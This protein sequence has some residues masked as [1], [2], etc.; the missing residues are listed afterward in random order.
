MRQCDEKLNL[1]QQ[2]KH[3]PTIIIAQGPNDTRQWRKKL[4]MLHEF[5]LLTIAAN[6]QDEMFPAVGWQ[7]FITERMIQRL[8][9]FPRWFSD[10]MLS[11]RYSLIPICNL[12]S[13]AL[14]T[15]IDVIYA[16]QL[17]HNRHLLWA[18]EGSNVPDLGGAES[19][20][21]MIWSEGLV[22]FAFFKKRYK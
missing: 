5:P 17:I 22:L 13:D 1:Y 19:E 9:I 16:R 18:T 21:Y 11:A 7:V 10:R 3:G 8:L 14:T 4:K 12:G 6:S 2:E 15:M 20:D